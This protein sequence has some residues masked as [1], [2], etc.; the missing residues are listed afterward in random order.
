MR[1][2]EGVLFGR[3]LQLHGMAGAI[4]VPIALLLVSI[5]IV[6]LPVLL[7]VVAVP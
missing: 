7:L 5:Q 3:A 1:R 4:V 2:K 6:L